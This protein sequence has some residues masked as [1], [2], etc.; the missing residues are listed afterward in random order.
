M[1]KEQETF[2]IKRLHREE[3]ALAGYE[4]DAVDDA[5][6][7]RLADKL[8]TD[9]QEQMFWISLDLIAESMGIPKSGKGKDDILCKYH[10]L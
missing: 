6:M 9:Y 10:L 3:L 8:S 1:G 7:E 4:A 2:V 5:T